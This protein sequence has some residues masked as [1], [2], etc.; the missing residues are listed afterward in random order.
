[1]KVNDAALEGATL[2]GTET[3]VILCSRGMHEYQDA[4]KQQITVTKKDDNSSANYTV[5][6]VEDEVDPETGK[7]TDANKY[8]RV[9]LNGLADGEYEL[10]IGKDLKANNEQTLGTAMK[11]SFT[12]KGDDQ[13]SG[14]KLSSIFDTLLNFFKMIINFF[15]GLF[16]K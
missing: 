16:T 4:N 8:I 2:K 10:K 6:P 5:L 9:Q 12:V 14:N 1:M 13:G 7:H 15:K 11:V 3:I